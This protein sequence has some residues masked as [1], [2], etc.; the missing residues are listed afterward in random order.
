MPSEAHSSQSS[1]VAPDP[2]GRHL[3]LL[4]YNIQVGISTTL[5]RHYLTKSWKHV[6][7]A[8]RRFENLHRIAGVLSEFDI[9][10]LQELDAGSHR[11]GYVNLTQFLAEQAGF[12]FW[13]H[14]LNRDMGRLAQHGSGLL[15]RYRP[16]KVEEF[17]LPGLL[18]GRG[19][20][21]ARF[22]DNDNP[23]VLFIV[24]LAL[25]SRSR[26]RQLDFVAERVQEF[27]H[28]I[29][30]GDMNCDPHSPEMRHLFARTDLFE[31]AEELHTFPSWRPARS[32]DHILVTP[33]L[34]VTN[35]HVLNHTY[36]DHLPIAMEIAL[37]D[38]VHP[39]R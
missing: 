34:E 7:R 22:G 6:L 20:L 19:M 32:I 37:P 5:P 31:P 35:C 25:S 10:G 1:P 23:L 13:H 12:P 27:K 30:M 14:Q 26:L 2:S 29:V 28:S 9:I 36:S 16:H 11:T 15:S 8:S 24:H 18:P 33:S 39:D 17:R 4:S 3:K 38:G 21:M